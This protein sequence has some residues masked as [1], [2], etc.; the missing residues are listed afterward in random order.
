L[1]DKPS[2]QELAYTSVR[3]R[4]QDGRFGAG[5]RLIISDIAKELGTSPI[6]IREALR[7][8]EAEGLVKFLHNQGAVVRRVSAEDYVDTLAT[9]ALLE[10]YMTA[11]VSDTIDAEGIAQLR[12]TNER[13]ATAWANGDA[14]RFGVINK[15]FHFLLYRYCPNRLMVELA[16]AAWARLENVRQTSIALLPGRGQTTLA[17]HEA[18]IAA[19]ER[20]A[21]KDEIERLAREHKLGTIRHFRKWQAENGIIL[22]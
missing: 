5:S 14:G 22:D 19:L 11:L 4:I 12:S 9:L 2:R 8:L 15:E 18:I 17:E 20:H 3:Q 6:P 10:G 21:P 13:M 7:R 16:N 1:G